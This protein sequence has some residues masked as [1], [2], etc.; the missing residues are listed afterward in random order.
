MHAVDVLGAR[1]DAHQDDALA[2]GRLRLGI[3]GR[4]Y[5]FA[6]RRPRRGR[7]ALGQHLPLGPGVEGR[8]QKL[9]ERGRIDAQHRLGMIDQPFATHID[10]DL[11]GRRRRALAVARLQHPQLLLLNRELDILHVAVMALEQLADR[12][13]LLEHLRHHLFHRRQL[14]ALGLLAGDGQMLRRADAGHDILALG[15][16]EILAIELVGPGRRVARE[17][18]AGGAI[19]AHIAEHHGLD[20]DRRA[21]A[22]RD[23]V[24]AAIGDG[25]LIHPAAE[26]GADGTPELVRRILR[27]RLLEVLLDDILVAG[28]DLAPILGRKLGIERGAAIE[29]V[30]LEDLLEQMMLHAQH[31]LAIHLDEAAIAVIG[32]ALVA[33]A[34]GQA[35]DGLVIEAE[36]EHRIHHAR[37]R[38]AR[39][40]AD[41]DEQRVFGIAELGADQR[42]DMPDAGFDRRLEIDRILPIV[43]IEIGADFRGDGQARRDRQ[44]EIAH[45]G[46]VGSLA[47]QQ[48]L[49]VGAPFGGTITEAVDPFRHVQPIPRSSRNP[50]RGRA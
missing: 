9:V 31:D 22:G 1:L 19:V 44:A 34:L 2:L 41:R 18:D 37:H 25:A 32:E 43:I 23:L 7:Q 46:E 11:Q 29:L 5:D 24:Q 30:L 21:P 50:R 47:A 40:G 35:H 16:D 14:G 20:I 45:L 17:G 42:F 36:I 38:G 10:G 12:E 3:L 13:Q 48:I 28:H 39:T 27:E 49:H 15:I 6:R 33:T 8:M 26:H 4:E